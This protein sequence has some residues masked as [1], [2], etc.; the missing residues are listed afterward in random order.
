[1][2]INY[3][4][5]TL[6]QLIEKLSYLDLIAR[7]K[8]MF[9][10]LQNITTN[11]QQQINNIPQGDCIP[12]TGTEEGK[13]VTGDINFNQEGY[14]KI[15]QVNNTDGI[16]RSKAIYFGWD[17]HMQIYASKEG[18]GFFKQS[19]IQLGDEKIFL[20]RYV[21]NNEIDN[22]TSEVTIS[23]EDD[24]ILTYGKILSNNDYSEV[25][26]TN[27]L[28]YAQRAYVDAKIAENLGNTSTVGKPY[29][30]LVVLLTA[31]EI[32]TGMFDITTNILENNLG[33]IT[34]TREAQGQF[35]I[36]SPNPLFH[37]DK[38]VILTGNAGDDVY[39][40]SQ[41]AGCGII[42]DN[43]IR[44]VTT[45]N[46]YDNFNDAYLLNIPIE[47][48]VY[49]EPG[50]ATFDETITFNN[51]YSLDEIKTGGKWLGKDIYRKVIKYTQT[52]LTTN[53]VFSPTYNNSFNFLP[54]IPD[55]DEIVTFEH[56]CMNDGDIEEVG[57]ALFANIRV[58]VVSSPNNFASVVYNGA[59]V[60][61]MPDT[62]YDNFT[63]TL[64]YTKT[65]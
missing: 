6:S 10:K 41:I 11:L 40:K 2:K 60:L 48:R 45:S 18:D 51:S 30:S 21:V 46:A 64:E 44:L 12:L 35:N 42:D 34:V 22:T 43:T 54:L 62:L 17:E 56:K 7:L 47:I 53:S 59:A 31:T 57:K 37:I 58:Q 3:T 61:N 65:T 28:I 26:P 50:G 5:K 23:L 29:K 33:D 15:K 36:S 24:R 20:Q 13:P 63:L 16:Q 9:Y 19:N 4:N 27:K 52:D 38:T 55:L 25:D 8:V 1:M 49:N 39:R 32:G 14:N